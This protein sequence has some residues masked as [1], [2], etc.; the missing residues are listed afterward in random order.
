[1]C[2]FGFH[3]SSD[4]FVSSGEVRSGKQVTIVNLC[5]SP[6]IIIIIIIIITIIGRRLCP[7]VGRRPHHAVSKL[8]CLVQSSTRSCRSSICPGRLSTA[9]LVF[10]V[11]F[12]LSYG[13]HVVTREVHWSSLWRL[14]SPAQVHIIFLTYA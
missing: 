13:L 10:F 5:K 8:A 11:V 9:W 1:M 7:V 12:S 3:L 4:L 2:I 6:H 14:M